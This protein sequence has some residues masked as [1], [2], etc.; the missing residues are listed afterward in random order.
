M[1]NWIEIK[2]LN[3]K[4]SVSS[5]GRVRNNNSMVIKNAYISPTGYKCF[6]FQINGIQTIKN[7]HRLYA[8]GF[9]PNPENK[10]VV[11]HIDGNKLNNDLSNLEWST[12]S[13]NINHAYEKNLRA[14]KKGVIQISLDGF[15]INEY[16]SQREAHRQTGVNFQS[17]NNVVNGRKKTAGGYIWK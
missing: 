17:I 8:Q 3:G 5:L 6:S 10:R 16:N 13:E 7:L 15:F 2:E 9:I 4:Y 11:N 1:E 14:N 12:Y